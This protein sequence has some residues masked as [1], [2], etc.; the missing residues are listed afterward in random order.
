M[1]SISKPPEISEIKYFP[2]KSFLMIWKIPLFQKK[3][4]TG[5]ASSCSYEEGHNEIV[6]ELRTLVAQYSGL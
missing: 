2:M 5:S 6:E 1:F 3:Y 4:P